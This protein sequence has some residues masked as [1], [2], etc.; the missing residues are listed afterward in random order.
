MVKNYPILE[1]YVD[2]LETF[3]KKSSGMYIKKI[4][5]QFWRSFGQSLGPIISSYERAK[6]Q[7]HNKMVFVL[8]L[9]IRKN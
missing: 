3:V 7:L 1:I 2:N 9:E 4:Q 5:I 8:F 6:M